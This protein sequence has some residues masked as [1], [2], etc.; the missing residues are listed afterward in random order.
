VLTCVGIKK[1]VDQLSLRKVIG[2]KEVCDRI[3]AKRRNEVN[4]STDLLKPFGRKTDK[5]RSSLGLVTDWQ[6]ETSELYN[7]LVSKFSK[8]GSVR[9]MSR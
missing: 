8:Q 2:R 1:T 6:D 7:D 5:L 3:L 9:Q 4:L